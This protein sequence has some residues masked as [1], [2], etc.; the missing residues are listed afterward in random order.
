MPED[1]A[2]AFVRTP[3]RPPHL[4]QPQS[5]PGRPACPLPPA[6]LSPLLRAHRLLP[7]LGT[8]RLGQPLG[9]WSLPGAPFLPL[10]LRPLQSSL[11]PVSDRPFQTPPECSEFL[12]F[13]STTL[14]PS[15][16]APVTRQVLLRYL[17]RLG[18]VSP[19]AGQ[20]PRGRDRVFLIPH[21][22]PSIQHSTWHAA[23][24]QELFVERLIK[25][26][27]KQTEAKLEKP[28]TRK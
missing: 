25:H 3:P 15:S 5:L 6:L 2:Q 14:P 13:S 9:C 8:R 19:A 18:L 21:H 27:N 10:L 4:T 1:G 11:K 28:Q 20:A 17:C 23:N 26:V 12:F 22:V 7:G 24:A 16:T